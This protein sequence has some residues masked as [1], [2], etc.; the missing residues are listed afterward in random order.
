LADGIVEEVR[1]L[2][3]SILPKVQIDSLHTDRVTGGLDD[4][5]AIVC[6]NLKLKSEFATELAQARQ[7]SLRQGHTLRVRV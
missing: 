1:I 5:A 6:T 2:D 7:H 3:S 4:V